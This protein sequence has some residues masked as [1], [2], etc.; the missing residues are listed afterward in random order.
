MVRFIGLVLIAVL[1]VTLSAA[2][3]PSTVQVAAAAE[4][5]DH[6][7]ADSSA[8]HEQPGLL[9]LDP[10]SAVW[11]IVLFVILLLIL[12]KFA[13]PHILQGLQGREEKIRADLEQAAKA[14]RDALA[15]M[16][17]YEAKL[18]EARQDARALIEEAK[19][20]AERFAAQLKATAQA[21]VDQI[22][23]RA[24]HEI[25]AAKEQA[26][27][28]LYTQTAALATQVAGSIIQRELRPED[29]EQLINDAVRQFRETQNN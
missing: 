7:A 13:W 9:D 11:S 23:Q 18:A 17:E 12:S 6:S 16:A 25:T 28:E 10:G 14:A 29:Q 27:V 5:T 19:V 4:S 3:L 2:L 1:A 15:T 26:L 24:E 22:R 8:A 20:G 21:E